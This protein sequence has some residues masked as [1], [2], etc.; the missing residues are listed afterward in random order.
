MVILELNGRFPDGGGLEPAWR[1]GFA[2]YTAAQEQSR[3]IR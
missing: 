3:Q 1:A 2:V